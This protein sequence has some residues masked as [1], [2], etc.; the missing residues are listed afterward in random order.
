VRPPLLTDT[1]RYRR[2]IVNNATSIVF[3]RMDGSL[4]TSRETGYDREIDEPRRHSQPPAPTRNRRDP[5][6]RRWPGSS[7]SNKPDQVTLMSR[8]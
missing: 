1:D 6:S 3:E 2:L 8:R 5:R 4:V 7:A